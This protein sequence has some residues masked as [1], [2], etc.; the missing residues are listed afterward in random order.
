M[1]RVNALAGAA[2]AF[3]AT[4]G[5]IAQAA[6][7]K[8]GHVGAPGSLFEASVNEFARCAN[9]AFDGAHTVTGFGSSQ[10]GKDRELLQKLKLG[11]VQFA[12]PSSV[13][14]SVDETFGVFEMPYIIKDRDH[15]RRVT[16]RAD[17]DT[18]QAAAKATATG[19]SAYF[20]NGFRH[21]TNNTRPIKTSRG[22]GRRQAAHAEGRLAREDVQALRREPDADG[23]LRGVHRAADRRDRRPGEPL[24]ADRLGQ[25]PGSAEVPVHHRPCVHARP[26]CWPPTSTSPRCRKACRPR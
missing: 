19:S 21:I 7:F 15:M 11:Q 12:L 18:F 17:G 6:E 10:L 24:R 25:V 4:C 14:S 23:V 13:M 5:C 20:E 26:M 9:E 1:N 16:G 8:F 22:S 3:A 2:F